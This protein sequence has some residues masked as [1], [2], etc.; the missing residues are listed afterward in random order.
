MCGRRIP[1]RDYK[2]V[3]P[4]PCDDGCIHRFMCKVNGLTCDLF[5]AWATYGEIELVL[6][7]PRDPSRAMAVRANLEIE[8]K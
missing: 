2:A 3:T 1:I 7:R 4:P 8:R 5:N 6:H